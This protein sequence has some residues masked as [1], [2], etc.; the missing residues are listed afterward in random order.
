MFD[1]CYYMLVTD[2]KK[3]IRGGKTLYNKYLFKIL[4]MCKWQNNNIIVEF[5]SFSTL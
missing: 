5:Y 1:N 2:P 3:L 4:L